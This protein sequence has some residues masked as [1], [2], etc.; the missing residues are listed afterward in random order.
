MRVRLRRVRRRVAAGELEQLRELLV[1]PRRDR[2]PAVVDRRPSGAVSSA[3]AQHRVERRALAA[4]ADA[5]PRPTVQLELE[6]PRRERE[7]RGLDLRDVEVHAAPGA[8]AVQEPGRE[9]GGDEARRERVGDRAVRADGLAVGPAGEEVVARERRALA[10][11]AGVV[12]VRPGL[13]VEA[14]ARPSRGRACRRRATRSR[15]RSRA[16]RAARSSRRP[17]RP[18]RRPAAARARRPAGC[19]RLNVTSRLPTFRPSNIGAP[20]SP[21]GFFGPSA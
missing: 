14:R 19:F 2:D 7:D 16:S 6:Q 5:R 4:V 1:G 10:A 13:A 17:R 15:G 20:S 21:C 12:A 9:R 18:T 11:E 3:H 8:A